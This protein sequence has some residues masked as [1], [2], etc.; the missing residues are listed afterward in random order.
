MSKSLAKEAFDPIPLDGTANF[1]R[2]S[3]P[4]ACRPCISKQIEGQQM[5]CDYLAAFALDANEVGTLA[6]ALGFGKP[7]A[8]K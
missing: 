3:N 2:R 6:D 1:S 5:L 4:E 8:E 7:T